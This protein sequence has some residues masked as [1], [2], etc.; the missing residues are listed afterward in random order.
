MAVG[1]ARQLLKDKAKK[2]IAGIAVG[3]PCVRLELRDALDDQRE[4]FIPGYGCP[5][6]PGCLILR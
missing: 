3:I 1:F 6:F 2:E 4:Q 5:G